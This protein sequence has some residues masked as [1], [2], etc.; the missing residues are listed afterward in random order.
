M[1]LQAKRELIFRMQS[2]YAEADRK[3]KTEIIDGIIAATDYH[4]KY[5]ISILR[6]E[7][8]RLRVMRKRHTIYDE[9]V[10]EVLVMIWHATNQICSK[11]LAPFLPEFIATLERFGHLNVSSEVKEKLLNLSSAT[12]DR[13]LKDERSKHPRG[14][15]TTKPGNLLKQ[16]IKIRTFSEWNETGP[17]FFEGDLVAHCGDHVDGIFLNTLVLTDIASCWTEFAPLL[18]K[19]D[20]DVTAAMTAIR[21]VLPF[22]L[23]GLDTDNGSEFINLEL[24]DYCQR[25][26]ITFTRSRP[27]KKNDQAHVEQKNGNVIRRTVGYDR[28]E[29]V[30][31]WNRLLDLYR[32]LR[33]YINYF[34]PS[35]KLLRK[36]RTGSRV[37]K[38]YDEA[39]TPYRRL[40]ESEQ[41]SKE[42]KRK[43]TEIYNSLDPI[44]L[45]EQIGSLQTN[46]L[47]ASADYI[48]VQPTDGHLSSQQKSEIKHGLVQPG[49]YTLKPFKGRKRAHQKRIP[50]TLCMRKAPTED[51]SLIEPQSYENKRNEV[52]RLHQMGNSIRAIAKELGM[53]RTTVAKYVNNP[54]APKYILSEPRKKPLSDQWQARIEEIFECEKKRPGN[55]NKTAL[56]IYKRIVA[57][58]YTGS[59]RTVQNLVANVRRDPS[60]TASIINATNACREILATSNPLAL[61][62]R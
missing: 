45:F 26:K 43:L 25:E 27:Y 3:R 38:K 41:V 53:S 36:E 14:K 54:D 24:F 9:S 44:A 18:R 28:F 46:L 30:E 6:N 39:Q 22:T 33:L 29:G 56:Q 32:V 7:D 17:G 34:Q 48:D 62:N 23:L 52:H 37:S 47:A 40:L 49:L 10:K 55:Q 11:R 15:S 42:C 58:G 35:C 61:I 31:A 4:R 51:T 60:R 1:S 8:K 5:V 20:V 19:S 50:H 21:A 57:E 12:I 13:L 59:E 2:Q 16:R